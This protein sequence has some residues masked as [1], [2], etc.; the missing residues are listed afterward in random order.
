MSEVKYFNHYWQR[1]QSLCP[2][3]HLLQTLPR[4]GDIGEAIGIFV[5]LAKGKLKWRHF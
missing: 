4:A 2:P 3:I 5:D 1:P